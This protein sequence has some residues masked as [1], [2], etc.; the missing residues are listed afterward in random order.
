MKRTVL[1]FMLAF[2]AVTVIIAQGN[3]RRGPDFFR[4]PAPRQWGGGDQRAVPRPTVE[5]AKI[6]GNLTIAQ[7]MI[8][9]NSNGITYLITGLT[10]FIGFID[11]F[12]E[13]ASVVLEGYAM[14]YPRNDKTRIMMAQKM[15]LNG[16]DYDLGRLFMNPMRQRMM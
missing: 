3:N 8:A 9:V 10:R 12:K 5:T 14:P 6:S 15:T 4:Q 7:G 16:K 1:F 2:C 13:G 11:G